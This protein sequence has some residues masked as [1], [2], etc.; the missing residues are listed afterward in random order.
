MVFS[1]LYWEIVNCHR[2]INIFLK[3]IIYQCLFSVKLS[4]IWGSLKA[5][6]VLFLLELFTCNM[7]ILKIKNICHIIF[8][9][10]WFPNDLRDSMILTSKEKRKHAKSNYGSEQSIFNYKE[11]LCKKRLDV[12]SPLAENGS[13]HR[14]LPDSCPYTVLISSSFHRCAAV[15][16]SP[17]RPMLRFWQKLFCKICQPPSISPNHLKTRN[18]KLLVETQKE[19]FTY[20]RQRNCKDRQ[21][22]FKSYIFGFCSLTEKKNSVSR[23]LGILLTWLL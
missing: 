21:R 2:N 15:K 13:E 20:H 7:F 8:G 11:E 16:G 12:F 10:L 22:C 14:P 4:D 3:Y 19:Q 23:F 9:I 18:W 1:K 6:C 17:S 5:A